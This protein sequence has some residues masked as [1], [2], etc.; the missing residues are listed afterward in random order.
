[1]SSTKVKPRRTVQQGRSSS[2]SPGRRSSSLPN[3]PAPMAEESWEKLSDVSL[4]DVLAAEA[5]SE[6]EIEMLNAGEL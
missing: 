5:L 2:A 1:M 4:N 3:A 6:G